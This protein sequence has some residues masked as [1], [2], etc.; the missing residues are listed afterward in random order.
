M[1][2]DKSY[3]SARKLF[4]HLERVEGPRPG[5]VCY[6][7]YPCRVTNG[8][9][10]HPPLAELAAMTSIAAA[11]SSGLI[12]RPEEIALV[13]AAASARRRAARKRRY[14]TNRKEEKGAGSV[15]V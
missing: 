1:H 7:N 4:P 6:V 12:W 3:Q 10:E 8:R 2:A 11:A 13:H 14:E 15:W 9:I 5:T